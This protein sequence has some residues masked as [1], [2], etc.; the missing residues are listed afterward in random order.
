M[1]PALKH[2]LR[3]A[4]LTDQC[5]DICKHTV[6][7]SHS[8]WKLRDYTFVTPQEPLDSEFPWKTAH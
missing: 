4:V 7:S 2:Q 3:L 1:L 8:S 5:K 6:V